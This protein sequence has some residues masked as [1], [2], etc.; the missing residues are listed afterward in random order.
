MGLHP[1]LWMVDHTSSAVGKTLD[2]ISAA[3]HV[4]LPEQLLEPWF[5]YSVVFATRR[6][7]SV[8]I[9]ILPMTILGV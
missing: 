3:L 8:S 2:S 1:M 5:C 9:F 6:V 7:V 4:L